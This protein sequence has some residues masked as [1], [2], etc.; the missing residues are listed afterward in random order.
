MAWAFHCEACGLNL[1]AASKEHLVE[2]V[3][4]HAQRAHHLPMTRDEAKTTVEQQA[5]Q[6]AA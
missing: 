4:R 6:E 2:V 5:T 3:Q 1:L